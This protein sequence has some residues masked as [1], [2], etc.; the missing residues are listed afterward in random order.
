MTTQMGNPEALLAALTALTDN[1]TQLKQ[2]VDGFDAGLVTAR[3]DLEIPADIAGKLQSLNNTLTTTSQLLETISIVP[4]IGTEAGVLQDAIATLQQPVSAAAS[5]ANEL[6]GTIRPLR[7]AVAQLEV[8]VQQLDRG[9]GDSIGFEQKL[10]QV[11]TQ[12]QSCIGGLPAGAPKD[13]LQQQF[14]TACGIAQPLV[15][16]AASAVGTVNAD[17]NTLEND[18]DQAQSKLQSLA[19]ISS[20][21]DSVTGTL[22]GILGPMQAVANALSE[23]VTVPYG[24][25][26]PT[27]ICYAGGFFPYP[28]DWKTPT[29][30][31][32]IRDILSGLS[33]VLAPVLDLLK[34][35]MNAI[36]N[37]LLSALHLNIT[38]PQIPGLGDLANDLQSLV[39]SLGDLQGKI[40]QFATDL[41]TFETQVQDA[42]ASVSVVQPVLTGCQ[43]GRRG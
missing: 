30:S 13:A 18:L 25:P 22:S 3:N 8:R 41:N 14:D 7:D 33:G 23:S 17:L 5:A 38:L 10:S 6:A 31:F 9:I 39:G 12:A 29:F 2:Q 16:R 20:A 28:C 34:S 24:P 36:L 26:Y 1:T 32:S 15:T 40:G 21:I 35:A 11:V 19:S 27:S 42:G 37:P 43:S 4:E